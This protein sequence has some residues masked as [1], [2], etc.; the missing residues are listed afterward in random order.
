MSAVERLAADIVKWAVE[1]S[2]VDRFLV[3]MLRLAMDREVVDTVMLA[4]ERSAIE[5]LRWR[6]IK[7]DRLA[8]DRSG[9]D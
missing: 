9:V 5:G 8:V 4:V 2:V 7:V 1:R 6:Y 3:D